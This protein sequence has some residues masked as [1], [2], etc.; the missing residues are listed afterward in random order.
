MI[1]TTIK[2]AYAAAALVIKDEPI[3]SVMSAQ[4]N[5]GRIIQWAVDLGFEKLVQSGQWP[6]DYRWQPF[7]RPTGH[8]LEI[9]PSHSVITISQ[10]PEARVQPRD[11]VFRENKRL[12]T[13]GWLTGLPNPRDQSSTIG[14]PHIL[15]VHGHQELTFAQLGIPNEHHWEGYAYRTDN[16]LNMP[17]E[18]VTPEPMVEQTD[19]E[20]VISLKEEIDRWRRDHGQE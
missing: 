7:A 17:H 9:L 16:L 13:Q 4:D 20:A 1:P 19:D 8:Y 10:V 6:F 12:N 5:G 2:T 15:L 14:L 3:L 18:V 11:V